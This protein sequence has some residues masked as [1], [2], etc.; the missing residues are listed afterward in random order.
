MSTS[1]C[2]ILLRAPH[3]TL[4][5]E[6]WNRNRFK[7]KILAAKGIKQLLIG[8]VES[9]LEALGEIYIH[10]LFFGKWKRQIYHHL[11]S[12]LCPHG[13]CRWIKLPICNRP[14]KDTFAIVF[15]FK[16]TLATSYLK[17]KMMGVFFSG[18]MGGKLPH[19]DN[20]EPDNP[21][22]AASSSH[23]NSLLRRCAWL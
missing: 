21:E 10:I 4:P 7:F 2:L 12:L 19:L 13:K 14:A 20:P 15:F 5:L 23:L 6:D 3:P 16:S 11:Y 17:D 22:P 1:L 9:P 8:D 18:S